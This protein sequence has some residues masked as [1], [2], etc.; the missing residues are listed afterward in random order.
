M[1]HNEWFWENSEKFLKKN[2]IFGVVRDLQIDFLNDSKLFQTFED[3][4]LI[5]PAKG[6]NL[7]RMRVLR[8]YTLKKYYVITKKI[9]KNS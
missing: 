5:E 3:L 8:S 1:D 2:R 9:R 6:F 7:R 4:I